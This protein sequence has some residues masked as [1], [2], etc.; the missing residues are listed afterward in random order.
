MII[1]NYGKLFLTTYNKKENKN[2][3][4][5]EFFWN[6]M[7][8]LFFSD[9]RSLSYVQNSP[10]SNPANKK[11]TE[12][13]KIKL[14]KSKINSGEFDASM[15]IGGFAGWK[16]NK[17]G[18]LINSELIST[19]SFNLAGDYDIN[20]D[21][22]DIY[23]SWIGF[24]LTIQF[25]GISFLF[26]NDEILYNIYKGW[27]LYRK[28]LNEEIN[29][30]FKPNQIQTWNSLWLEHI[31]TNIKKREVN[32]N[33]FKDFKEKLISP[34]WFKVFRKLSNTYPDTVQ[35]AYVFS[36]GQTNET[37]GII[38]IQLNKISGLLNGYKKYF[39]ENDFV[40]NSTIFDEI[41]GTA[42][43]LSTICEFGSIGLLA[44]KPELLRLEELIVKS[45]KI[46]NKIKTHYKKIKKDNININIYKNYIMVKLNKENLD[47][48]SIKY[49]K[50]LIYIN[51]KSRKNSWKTIDEL[52]NTT[53]SKVFFDK[54][55]EVVKITKE[56]DMNNELET[57]K[58]LRNTFI[59]LKGNF[60]E[61]LSLIKLDYEFNI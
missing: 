34:H 59:E 32:F 16:T 48:E 6:E 25:N 23:L 10:F 39:G 57:L 51:E 60:R 9:E 28:L 13:E 11:K 40:N 18:K 2:L 52:L 43:S 29:N 41:Y 49:A 27:K 17:N 61:F 31:Y 47:K 24:G 30:N 37:Y 46:K 35:N 12:D 42:Y 19:T 56:N 38:P 36:L 14:F 21:E 15:F 20:I 55:T 8:S 53:S 4:P 5:K 22:D 1:N 50:T 26:D 33:P 44:L 45:E 58:E 3:T 54:L 7:Y